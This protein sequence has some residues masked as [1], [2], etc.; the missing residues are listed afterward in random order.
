[1][2]VLDQLA[3]ELGLSPED[4]RA[5]LEGLAADAIA[6]NYLQQDPQ[7]RVTANFAGHVSAQ[8][9]DLP[10]G[11]DH[12]G[13][14]PLSVSGLH[15]LDPLNLVVAGLLG[16]YD[17]TAFGKK[18][19]LAGPVDPD[20]TFQTYIDLDREPNLNNAA[21]SVGVGSRRRFLITGTGQSD[22]VQLAQIGRIRLA[23]GVNSVHYAG[24][25]VSQV[26]SFAHGLNPDVPQGVLIFNLPP[27]NSTSVWRVSALDATNVSVSGYQADAAPLTTDQNFFWVAIA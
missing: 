2:T 11:D 25:N 21:V 18:R 27:L 6:P 12:L 5:R 14:T 17:S 23:L 4:V 7:G 24:A 3:D 15:W 19:L 16:S 8:G 26:K 1:V 10:A 20:G 13:V 22:F 9:L